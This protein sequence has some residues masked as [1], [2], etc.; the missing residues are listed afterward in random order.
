MKE[1]GQG[2][3]MG[4]DF[5]DRTVG[6]AVSDPLCLIAQPLE[7]IRRPEPMGLS[8]TINRLLEIASSFDVSLIILGY[9]KH[10]N[11]DQGERCE[12]TLVFRDKLAQKLDLPIVLLDERLSTVSAERA[13]ISADVRRE[14]RRNLVDMTAAS[15]IL[16]GYLDTKQNEKRRQEDGLI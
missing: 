14:K 9:P 13:L 8:K 6:V 4:L 5:G 11:N 15:I 2:R 16:Q 7:V 10:M 12:K 1:T 3:V